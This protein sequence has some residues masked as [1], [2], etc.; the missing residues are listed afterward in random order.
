M[1][2]TD[3]V[4][5][6]KVLQPSAS[7]SSRLEMIKLCINCAKLC[8]NQK[9]IQLCGRGAQRARMRSSRGLCLSVVF[10]AVTVPTGQPHTAA[11]SH[12]AHFRVAVA[13]RVMRCYQPRS[14]GQIRRATSV[15]QRFSVLT[16]DQ[17][18]DP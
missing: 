14:R 15:S 5:I 13:V 16:L 7:R 6:R 4:L 17:L 9:L 8:I 2:Y 11:V 3:S 18:I 1:F 10:P 12:R